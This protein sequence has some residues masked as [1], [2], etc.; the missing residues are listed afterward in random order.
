MAV[1]LEMKARNGVTIRFD[2]DAYASCSAEEIDRRRS[3]QRREITR[4]CRAQLEA[5]PPEERPAFLQK[6]DA[7]KGT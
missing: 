2:D 5:L 7:G 4:L 6:I 1:V 3:R